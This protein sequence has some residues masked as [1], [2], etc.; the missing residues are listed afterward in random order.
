MD[1]NRVNEKVRFEALVYAVFAALLPLNQAVKLPGGTTINQVTG[2]VVLIVFALNYIMRNRGRL[3]I[4]RELLPVYLFMGWNFLCSMWAIDGFSIPINLMASYLMLLMCLKREFNSKELSFIKWLIITVYVAFSL[5]IVF[6]ASQNNVRAV[7]SS[8]TGEADPNSL[9]VTLSFAIILSLDMVF[10]EKKRLFPMACMLSVS[11]AV[12]FTGSRTGII[13]VLVAAFYLTM[14][15]TKYS[16]K[17]IISI[18]VIVFAMYITLQI[19]IDQNIF[20]LRVLNRLTLSDI[21][22]TGGNGRTE[23]WKIYLEAIFANPIRMLIG[24]GTGSYTAITYRFAFRQ[25]SP[26]NDYIGYAA[27]LGLVGLFIFI[28]LLVTFIKK[29]RKNNSSIS[30]ALIILLMVGCITIRYF[31]DKAALNMLILAWQ[32]SVANGKESM[33]INDYNATAQTKNRIAGYTQQGVNYTI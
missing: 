33:H 15:K 18:F 28:A 3:S 30:V 4:S 5:Y 11:I 17:K 29:G 10:S 12:L 9:A 14:K 24:Y 26:H 1:N 25:I 31:E 23:I 22:E 32:L 6:V 20:N 8:K 27:T 2:T 7:L 13:A 16:R 21:T 19:L